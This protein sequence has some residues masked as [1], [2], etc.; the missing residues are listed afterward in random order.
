[1]GSHSWTYLVPQKDRMSEKGIIVQHKF[2]QGEFLVKSISHQTPKAVFEAF[3]FGRGATFLSG[4]F[5]GTATDWHRYRLVRSPSPPLEFS[6]G[7]NQI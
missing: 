3:F 4:P 5:S 7:G 2:P 1:M 6:P